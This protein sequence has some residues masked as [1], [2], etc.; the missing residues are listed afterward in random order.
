MLCKYCHADLL[1]ISVA[2]NS[3]FFY[4]IYF[5]VG[6]INLSFAYVEGESL[7]MALKDVAL[8]SGR[9]VEYVGR[10]A[11]SYREMNVISAVK[12]LIRSGLHC[13]L[14]FLV[15]LMS[16]PGIDCILRRCFSSVAHCK[17]RSNVF[18][19]KAKKQKFL[20]ASFADSLTV[21]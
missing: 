5:Y 20:S 1:Q 4:F 6:C 12:L 2:G 14:Y 13:A 19:L 9:Q 11:V 15:W 7:L 8:S 10:R 18:I 3:P 16:Q 21:V 17:G